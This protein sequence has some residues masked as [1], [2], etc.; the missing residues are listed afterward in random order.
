MDEIQSALDLFVPSKHTSDL[1]NLCTV[2]APTWLSLQ[3]HCV[4]VQERFLSLFGDDVASRGTLQTFLHEAVQSWCRAVQ[5]VEIPTVVTCGVCPGV[6]GGNVA[7]QVE[8]PAV[9]F[10]LPGDLRK[11]Q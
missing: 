11:S 2:E 3:S 5:L 10:H 6:P 7:F 9:F 8:G 4:F 1:C